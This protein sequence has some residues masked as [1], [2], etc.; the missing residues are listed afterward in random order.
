[1]DLTLLPQQTLD[2]VAAMDQAEK[3]GPAA[4]AEL[5]MLGLWL[6][7]QH[8]DQRMFHPGPNGLKPLEH[9]LMM[10][11]KTR[12]S[13]QPQFVTSSMLVDLTKWFP[14]PI[15]LRRPVIS[16]AEAQQQVKI[17][18]AEAK[19]W[20]NRD[21]HALWSE[22]LIQLARAG[23]PAAQLQPLAQLIVKKWSVK[24][25]TFGF[26][27]QALVYAGDLQPVKKMWQKFPVSKYPGI[28][29][30]CGCAKVLVE[31]N[32]VD[33]ARQLLDNLWAEL[34]PEEQ[35]QAGEQIAQVYAYLGDSVTARDRMGTESLGGSLES[36][37]LFEC[38]II[39]GRHIN[40]QTFDPAPAL[41][42][43]EETEQIIPLKNRA[44]EQIGILRLLLNMGAY[45]TAWRVLARLQTTLL[46]IELWE[47]LEFRTNDTAAVLWPYLDRHPAPISR[48]VSG[49][50]VAKAQ[51]TG[52]TGGLWTMMQVVS[53]LFF[54]I[55]H[56]AGPDEVQ[57]LVDFLSAWRDK[58][59]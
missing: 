4:L 30:R 32:K 29:I 7:G 20:K 59:A 26:Y 1:M 3:K 24:A 58:I 22:S 28:T 56:W 6:A 23:I 11:E 13:Q 55:K 19:Q 33:E 16:D 14:E 42:L 45:E 38:L 15:A 40:G 21:N 36:R 37:I 35:A 52:E 18:L 10:I 50:L 9:L 12:A 46:K 31:I 43:A 49:L 54:P 2:I 51:D 47:K 8:S 5:A 27:L 48:F 39:W 57:R 41:K 53:G 44:H 17:A 34:R 25:D